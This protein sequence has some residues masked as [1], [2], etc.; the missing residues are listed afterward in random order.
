M[1]GMVRRGA[2]SP[3]VWGRWGPCPDP[4][5]LP[6]CACPSAS[7][8]VQPACVPENW[9]LCLHKHLSTNDA[10]CSP[11]PPTAPCFGEPPACTL[12]PAR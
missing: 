12:A 10:Q 9:S 8:R 7:A 11:A 5:G 2:G 3:E 1:V 4:R 6:S